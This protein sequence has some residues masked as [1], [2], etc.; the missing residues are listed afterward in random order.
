MC[1]PGWTP[2]TNKLV[3]GLPFPS[4]QHHQAMGT[5]HTQVMPSNGGYIRTGQKRRGGCAPED[6]GDIYINT[7]GS[8]YE[9]GGGWHDLFNG[10]PSCIPNTYAAN[11]MGHALAGV[12][13][14][15]G[16]YEPPQQ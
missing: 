6:H 15:Q 2:A 9:P 3:Q 12:I 8:H 11:N 16:A 7:D 14:V 5:W 10:G 13:C 1:A 4:L